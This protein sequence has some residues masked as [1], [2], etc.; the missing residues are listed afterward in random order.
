MC[1]KSQQEDGR[2]AY[3]KIELPRGYAHRMAFVVLS[4]VESSIH[5]KGTC[6]GT[7]HTGE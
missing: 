2:C 6:S 7:T 3:P 1:N 5:L 4:S